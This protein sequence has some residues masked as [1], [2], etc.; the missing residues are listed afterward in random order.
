MTVNISFYW[1]RILICVEF[2]TSTKDSSLK[3]V[4]SLIRRLKN[5]PSEPLP[6]QLLNE[7]QQV[8]LAMHYSEVC[9]SILENRPKNSSEY[10]C[11]VRATLHVMIEA[12]LEFRNMF[13]REILKNVSNL[14]QDDLSPS[15]KNNFSSF[16]YF[17]RLSC[18]LQ[19]VKA[20]DNRLDGLSLSLKKLVMLTTCEYDGFLLNIIVL[21]AS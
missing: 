19:I 14:I 2:A 7:I 21:F 15:D 16:R 4:S 13:Y 8:N 1:F 5:I 11:I 3:R 10:M 12:D 9:S 17:Y 20:T 6:Q 18:E